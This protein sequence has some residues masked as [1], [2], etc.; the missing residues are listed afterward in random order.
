MLAFFSPSVSFAFSCLAPGLWHLLYRP[1]CWGIGTVADDEVSLRGLCSLSSLASISALW[2]ALCLSSPSACTSVSLFIFLSLSLPNPG[3]LGD[4]GS[5][6][7]DE[8]RQL[9]VVIIPLVWRQMLMGWSN[10]V[11]PHVVGRENAL[12]MPGMAILLRWV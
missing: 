11:C 4:T 3:P 7:D 8:L 9:S 5:G 2:P 10:K 1:C 12:V 6:S